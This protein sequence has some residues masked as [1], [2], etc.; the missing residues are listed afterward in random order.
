[1]GSSA[2]IACRS[3]GESQHDSAP[4]GSWLYIHQTS[5]VANAIRSLKSHLLGHTPWIPRRDLPIW[6]GIWLCRGLAGVEWHQN[7]ELRSST[8][9]CDNPRINI[10]YTLKT[11]VDIETEPEAVSS[12]L[13]FYC[14][15]RNIVPNSV[16]A[17]HIDS[18]RHLRQSGHTAASRS[19]RERH[20]QAQR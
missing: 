16:H 11:Y 13:G 6:S 8:Y 12:A 15:Y 5:S 20:L 1:M 4:V 18:F 14:L 19:L 17:F 9:S 7:V 2:R 3:F 10:E